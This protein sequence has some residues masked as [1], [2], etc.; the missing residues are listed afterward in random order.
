MGMQNNMVPY[1]RRCTRS[2]SRCPTTPHKP[3]MTDPVSSWKLGEIVEAEGGLQFTGLTVQGGPIILTLVG[4][5]APFEPSSYQAES[6]VKNLDLRL[7]KLTEEK[8]ECMQACVAEKFSQPRYKADAFKPFLHKKEEYPANLRTKLQTTGLTK[9]RFW[10]SNKKLTEP[11]ESYA[12]ATF[13]AKVML[14]GIWYAE[15]AWGLSLHA[16]DLMLT[17]DSPIPECPF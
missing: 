14:K 12:G 17:K 5:V 3:K 16:T 2:R 15:S 6:L 1:Y 7:D 10:D 9:T 8:L 11:P 13:E 4:C